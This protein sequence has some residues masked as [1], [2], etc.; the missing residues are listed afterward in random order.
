MRRGMAFAAPVELVIPVATV[1]GKK[2]FGRFMIYDDCDLL[3][4]L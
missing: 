3:K 2:Y 1:V 4:M